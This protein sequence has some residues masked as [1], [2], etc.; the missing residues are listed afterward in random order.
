MADKAIETVTNCIPI[1]ILNLLV[2][3]SIAN[4]GF[5]KSVVPQHSEESHI[6]HQS[7]KLNIG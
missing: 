4:H 1:L 6:L 5:R 7:W 2:S 3:G